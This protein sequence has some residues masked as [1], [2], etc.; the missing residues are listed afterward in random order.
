[1]TLWPRPA[2]HVTYLR[3]QLELRKQQASSPPSA[4]PAAEVGVIVFSG[5]RVCKLVLKFPSNVG[6]GITQHPICQDPG[7]PGSPAVAMTVV[8]SP[9]AS[10]KGV[11]I[12]LTQPSPPDLAD[13]EEVPPSPVA[14]FL[15]RD[16]QNLARKHDS[17]AR[18]GRGRKRVKH[19]DKEQ[20]KKGKGKGNRR[21]QPA[22]REAETE[23]G[24]ESSTTAAPV[25][26]RA[27]A[28]ASAK[29]KAKAKSTP[30]GRA[31]PKSKASPGAK[32]KAP[33]KRKAKH[34][35]EGDDQVDG[36]ED[37]STSSSLSAS[38][39][40]APAEAAAPLQTP[41][42]KPSSTKPRKSTPAK[43]PLIDRDALK[44]EI[45]VF[46]HSSVVPY[47]SRPAV[48]LKVNKNRTDEKLTQAWWFAFGCLQSV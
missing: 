38:T 14:A 31:G 13:S 28:K 1:M 18:K 7:C 27:K 16:D 12:P 32:A 30:R 6:E 9:F 2:F 26:P 47:W 21:S 39:S 34:L 24:V 29:A 25:N 4:A 3:Q 10:E 41:S 44:K 37:P 22:K 45:L 46:A 33:S 11:E 35:S 48:G 17:P 40:P 5:D 19:G 8:D 15:T 20:E 23:D 43:H 36:G 42:P